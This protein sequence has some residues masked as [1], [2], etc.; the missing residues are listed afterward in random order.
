VA[1]DRETEAVRSHKQRSFE[2]GA[3]SV[4][5][6]YLSLIALAGLSI[7]ATS[8]VKWAD[9][10]AALAVLPLIVREGREAMCGKTCGCCSF[11]RVHPICDNLPVDGGMTL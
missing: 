6:A 9:P 7:N 3:Q 4:V 10:V 8:H 5:C 2:G 1:R 11:R